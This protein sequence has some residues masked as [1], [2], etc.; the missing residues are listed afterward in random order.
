M[1]N[2]L[3]CDDH[4]L[5]REAL[6]GSIRQAW[7]NCSVVTAV[8]YPSAWKFAHN[9]FD[10]CLTDLAMPGADPLDGIQG[11]MA[12]VEE[13]PVLVMTGLDNGKIFKK[14][15]GL[16]VAGLISKLEPVNVFETAI[17]HVL[18]GKRFLSHRFAETNSDKTFNSSPALKFLTERQHAVFLLVCK[19]RTNKEIAAILEVAPS[20]I[21]THVENL[22]RLLQATNR[23]E[24]AGKSKL[25]DAIKN[26]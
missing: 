19:G 26:A 10:L 8:D 22:M 25:L 15:W 3:I 9:R 20:T 6:T 16:G 14:L 2:C 12:R 17:R 21:K 11:I 24:L 4:P 18:S 13:A 1:K 23:T 7:P 5:L